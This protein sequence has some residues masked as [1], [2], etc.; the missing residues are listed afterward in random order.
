MQKQALHEGGATSRATITLGTWRGERRRRAPGARQNA[1]AER[2]WRGAIPET[3]DGPRPRRGRAAKKLFFAS[4]Q[5]QRAVLALLAVAAARA[6]PRT[7]SRAVRLCCRFKCVPRP[8]VLPRRRPPAVHR[9]PRGRPARAGPLSAPCAGRFQS[10][11]SMLIWRCALL[12]PCWRR[13]SPLLSVRR[14]GSRAQN[15]NPEI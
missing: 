5:T 14:T 12:L 4:E 3:G 13:L 15:Q 8:P 1:V 11:R 2:D 6:Q 7:R 10:A 9:G